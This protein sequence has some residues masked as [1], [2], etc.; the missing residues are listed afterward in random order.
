[1]VRKE[2]VSNI[3]NHT[4]RHEKS[5]MPSNITAKALRT[6]NFRPSTMP[7][8]RKTT[9]LSSS[10]IEGDDDDDTE[11]R[12]G[13]T[14]YGPSTNMSSSMLLDRSSFSPHASSS[15][16]RRSHQ[17]CS[18]KKGSKLGPW[19]ER[20][21]MLQSHQSSNAMK[22]QHAGLNRF[23]VVCLDVNDP[24]KKAQSYTDVTILDTQKDTTSSGGGVKS[25]IGTTN[26]ASSSS[27][28]VWTLPCFLHQHAAT[29][30]S[31]LG[32]DAVQNVL[33]WFSITPTTARNVGLQ[34][35]MV[36]RVYDAILLPLLVSEDEPNHEDKLESRFLVICTQVCER[37]HPEKVNP[38]P[39]SI[40]KIFEAKSKD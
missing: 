39:D 11:G 40:A 23:G 13:G 22:L 25:M 34:K 7:K 19:S 27:Q 24:R 5:G 10:Q 32:G 20:L 17:H 35:G 6:M 4:P 9:M 8:A 28:L 37:L 26:E 30:D 33:A 29:S 38:V 21:A 1:M 14:P 2:N 16:P 3:S 18:S 12:A 15:A 36:L 31:G